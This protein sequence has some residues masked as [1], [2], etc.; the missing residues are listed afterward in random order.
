MR[1]K[2]TT[3]GG[4]S[5]LNAISSGLGSSMA[6]D[7]PISVA[8]SRGD[9]GPYDP[10]TRSIL[11]LLKKAYGIAGSYEIHVDSSIPPSRG[12]KSSS[13]YSTALIK[14]VDVLEGLGIKD[15]EVLRLSCLA[16]LEAGVSITGAFDDASASFLGGITLADN[17][18]MELLR[19]WEV[20]EGLTVI[21]AHSGILRKEEVKVDSYRL[22]SKLG[23]LLAEM[24]EEGRFF[25]AMTING[26][27]TAVAQGYDQSLAYEAMAA[28]ALAA[29]VTGTGP[30]VAVVT[31]EE[32]A[33]KVEDLARKFGYEV[34]RT[35]PT[36]SKYRVEVL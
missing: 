21:I 9:G 20:D 10:L 1:V 7:L 34:L 17:S 14:A 8:V 28:G 19:R 29:G 35:K 33:P 22:L 30:A 11:S 18:K 23:K 16:S 36:N 15:E 4:I 24:V 26:M 13:A 32:L 12:L 6:V 31:K 5:I 27:L 25:E 2:C 3:N